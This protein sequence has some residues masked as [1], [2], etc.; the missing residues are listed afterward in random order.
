MPG[1]KVAV[2]FVG[3][4]VSCIKSEQRKIIVIVFNNFFYKRKAIK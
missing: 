3:V 4:G 2:V 1:I